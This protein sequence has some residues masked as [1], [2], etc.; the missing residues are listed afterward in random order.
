MYSELEKIGFSNFLAQHCLDAELSSEKAA[1]VISESRE[2]YLIQSKDKIF[3]ATLTGKLRFAST[4]RRDLPAVGDWV[5]FSPADDENAVIESVLPRRSCLERSAV[6]KLDVQIIAANVDTAFVAANLS[7]NKR[8][9]VRPAFFLALSYRK[10]QLCARFEKL[11]CRIE[12]QRSLFPACF[13]GLQSPDSTTKNLLAYVEF[14]LVS[15]PLQTPD[16]Q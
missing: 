10:L 6:G 12:R 14:R 3:R 7:S 15:C 16:R 4:S 1:R 13:S 5:A 2:R 9:R 8:H 11:G